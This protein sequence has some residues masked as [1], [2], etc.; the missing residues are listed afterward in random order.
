MEFWKRLGGPV[1]DVYIRTAREGEAGRA[2]ETR[3]K[4]TKNFAARAFG[5]IGRGYREGYEDPWENL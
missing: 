4:I 1:P 2:T 5:G 3:E